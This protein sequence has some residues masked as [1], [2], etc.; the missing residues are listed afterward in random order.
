[1]L[2]LCVFGVLFFAITN[3]YLYLYYSDMK[4]ME[5]E[6]L[7]S[8][9]NKI[10]AK[11]NVYL[12]FSDFSALSKSDGFV[13]AENKTYGVYNDTEIHGSPYVKDGEP[14]HGTSDEYLNSI[15]QGY[16]IANSKI[17]WWHLI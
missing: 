17:K 1:M 16:A 11:K 12:S 15:L 6:K 5:V 10:K 2:L 7:L 4:I 13:R 14:F 8:E 3:C 9:I